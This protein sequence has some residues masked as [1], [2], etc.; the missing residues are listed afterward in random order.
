MHNRGIHCIT[1]EERIKQEHFN[2]SLLQENEKMMV[3]F[4][5][6]IIIKAFLNGGFL[7]SSHIFTSNFS[8]NILGTFV[9]QSSR[10]NSMFKTFLFVN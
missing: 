4:C 8:I 10:L 5:K 9:E 3:S 1:L 7:T 2:I 6:M